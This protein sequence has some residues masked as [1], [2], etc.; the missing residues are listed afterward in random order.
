M[1]TCQ[2]QAFAPSVTPGGRSGQ[3]AKAVED[4]ALSGVQLFQ[5]LGNLGCPAGLDCFGLL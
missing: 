1:P 3:R 2:A 5:V 4:V